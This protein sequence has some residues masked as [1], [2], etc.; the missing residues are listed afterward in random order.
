MKA[1]IF[2]IGIGLN[3]LLPEIFVH[4][5]NEEKDKIE[6]RHTNARTSKGYCV[7]SHFNRMNNK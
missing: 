1:V 6:L 2:Y 7:S 4:R 3:Q 5:L